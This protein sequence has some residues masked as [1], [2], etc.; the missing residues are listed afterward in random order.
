M[1]KKIWL[2]V[3]LLLT[4]HF[5][6][7]KSSLEETR[8]MAQSYAACT[9]K[10][11]RLEEELN[12]KM[13]TTGPGQNLEKIIAAYNRTLAEKKAELENLLKKK[14]KIA[15]SDE[16]DLL[17]SK[18]MIEIGRFADA[19]KIIG[20][21]SL[22]K[23]SLALEAKLQ[24]VIIHLIKRRSA[25]AL[26]LFKE[27]ESQLK[28]DTQFY[29]IYLTLAFS[30]PEAEV[31]EEYSLKFLACPE[32]PVM[33][34]PYKTRVYANLATLAKDN[35]QL[36]KAKGYLEKALALNSDLS[37]KANWEAELKHIALLKQPAPPLQAGI[38]FNTPPLTLAGL[39]GQVA[40]I[41]FWAP[42]C[43]H[44]RV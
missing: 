37:L 1:A 23:S 27:I 42:W 28:K 30:S 10:Y 4:L 36:E 8:Q 31:S 9:A 15:A 20:R 18:I 39:K 44:C 6:H 34:Q 32:L 29:N 7:S 5:C 17:R 33:L 35:H 12:A 26:A 40:V 25:E 22:A 2:A 38:W 19:E 11:N 14:G 21:L 41:D 13:K 3:L 24:K 16:L 43:D